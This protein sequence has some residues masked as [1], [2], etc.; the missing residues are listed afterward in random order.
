MRNPSSS[1]WFFSMKDEVHSIRM[2]KVCDLKVIPKGAK[3]V[4]YKWIIK[5]KRDSCWNLLS[6]ARRPTRVNSGDKRVTR[7]MANSSVNPA[8][9][10]HCAGVFIGT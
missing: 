3:I 4:G 7:E 6:I 2:K 9:H 5:T 1:N 8:S 10:G